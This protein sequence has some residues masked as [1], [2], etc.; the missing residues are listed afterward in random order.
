MAEYPDIE[1]MIEILGI[2][3]A[4]QEMEEQFFRRSAA[5][6]SS[7]VA[8]SLFNEIAEDLGR[9]CN[10]LEQR[11]QKLLNALDDLKKASEQ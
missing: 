6:S 8:K 1:N 5:A 2:A 4:R 11:R 3:I 9:Y 10:G 7:E